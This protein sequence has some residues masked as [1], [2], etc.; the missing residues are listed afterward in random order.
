[1]DGV[2]MVIDLTDLIEL[3]QKVN[4]FM[5]TYFDDEDGRLGVPWDGIDVKQPFEDV[6]MEIYMDVEKKIGEKI[7]YLI[8]HPDF[9]GEQ[10]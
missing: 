4:W 10:K 2:D 7:A 1:M 3:R 9:M 6:V 5:D 8:S